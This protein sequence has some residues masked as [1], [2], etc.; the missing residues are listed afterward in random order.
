MDLLSIWQD[1]TI[2]QLVIT[3][4]NVAV[5]L[6]ANAYRQQQHQIK[7]MDKLLLLVCDRSH[8]DLVNIHRN[9]DYEITQP[10][11]KDSR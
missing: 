9:G 4:L 11:N 8:R 2:T 6:L 3:L 10:L 1:M 7:Q 5:I